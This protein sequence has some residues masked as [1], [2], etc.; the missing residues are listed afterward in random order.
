MEFYDESKHKSRKERVCEMCGGPIHVGDYYYSE[1]GKFNGEFFSRDMHVHCHNMEQDFC[2]KIDNEFSWEQIIDYIQDAYCYKCDKSEDC[3]ICISD[4]PILKTKF[5][6]Q[7]EPQVDPSQ[8]DEYMDCII[9]GGENTVKVTRSKENGH[10]RGY[11]TSCKCR[12]I[13]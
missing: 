7:E 1:R 3:N 11:C 10:F 12:Y 8:N 9:C 13:E 6:D 2:D 5:S 4:C